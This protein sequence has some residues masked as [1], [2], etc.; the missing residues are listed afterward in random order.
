MERSFPDREGSVRRR[1]PGLIDVERAVF[2]HVVE[3]VTYTCLKLMLFRQGAYLIH[4]RHGRVRALPR[5]LVFECGGTLC[6]SI[7]V[8]S[9]TVSSAYAGLDYPAGSADVEP[10]GDRAGSP[11][12]GA[13]RGESFPPQ[14]VGYLVGA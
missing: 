5:T 1:T 12:G 14:H 7:P 8:T 11:R 6:G 3:Q 9:V 10:A 4:S 13:G 2:D